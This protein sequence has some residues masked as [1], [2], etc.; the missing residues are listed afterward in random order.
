MQDKIF[1]TFMPKF[2]H[3]WHPNHR[4]V[5]FPP[6]FWH[7]R[8]RR[9]STSKFLLQRF[10]VSVAFWKGCSDCMRISIGACDS[11]FRSSPREISFYISFSCCALMAT[12]YWGPY[13]MLRDIYYLSFQVS[14][15]V[16]CYYFMLWDSNYHKFMCH[17]IA[18]MI[19]IKIIFWCY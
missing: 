2:W 17:F 3:I 14:F 18:D 9:A 8:G 4:S 16:G 11:S 19:L 15:L 5:L 1:G 13:F 7:R 6:I 10:Q 12:Q